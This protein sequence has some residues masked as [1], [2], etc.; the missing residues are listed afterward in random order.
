MRDVI[1]NSTP[2]LTDDDLAS[3]AVYLKSLPAS[4]EEAAYSYDGATAAALLAGKTDA[5]GAALYAGNCQTCHRETGAAAPPF[6]PPLA[7]NPTVVDQDAASLIN[8]VLNGSGAAG[9]QG[10]AGRLPH[11]AVPRAADQ[12][13]DRRR[14]HLH[15]QRLGQP[16]GRGVRRAM[17]P[18]CASAPIPP[19]TGWSS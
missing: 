18:N 6:V 17:S 4:G 2:Y 10:P 11:A 12:P 13:A 16:R 3:I 9:G 14:R 1:N 7:G 5:V 8:I 19:A 15:P